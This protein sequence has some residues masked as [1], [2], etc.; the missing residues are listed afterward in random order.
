MKKEV[1]EF[2]KISGYTLEEIMNMDS[3]MDVGTDSGTNTS[4]NTVKSLVLLV[5]YFFIMLDNWKLEIK[6]Q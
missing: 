3:S 1:I 4:A 5:F 2:L 6:L